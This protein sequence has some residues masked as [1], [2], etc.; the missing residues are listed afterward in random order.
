MI[1]ML[2]DVGIPMMFIQWPLMIGALIPVI[3]VEALLIRRWVQLSYRDAFIGVTKANL[4]STLVGL[5]LAFLV[6]FVL[7]MVVLISVASAAEQRHWN[8][9][10][11]QAS[12]FIRIVE[13]TLGIAGRPDN[14]AYWQI[15]LA[16][17]LLLVPSF[18]VSVWVERFMCR[19][20]WPN[21][22]TAAVRRGVFLANLASYLVLFILACGWAAVEFYIHKG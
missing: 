11:L 14:A 5:P 12:P 6:I 16:A 3:I 9:D 10:S 13:F 15:P 18:Y 17:A 22:D 7:Q 4:F 2:A 19:R 8:L 20:A 21:S 1:T